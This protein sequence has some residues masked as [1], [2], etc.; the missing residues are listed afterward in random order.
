M[1]EELVISLRRVSKYLWQDRLAVI[2]ARSDRN[3][4]GNVIIC[5]HDDLPQAIDRAI[6]HR[7]RVPFLVFHFQRDAIE[8]NRV[9]G[10][11]YIKIPVTVDEILREFEIALGEVQC[12][13]EIHGYSYAKYLVRM[14]ELLISH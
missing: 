9:S 5:W 13:E 8:F 10:I 7:L 11:R 1:K 6:E 4:G 14:K 2:G 3:L 12:S